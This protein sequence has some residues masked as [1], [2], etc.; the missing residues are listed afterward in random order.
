[1]RNRKAELETLRA[2]LA[3]RLESFE[4]HQQRKDGALDKDSEERA[5]QTQNDEVVD[6][7]EEETRLELAQIKV[8]LERID[9]GVGDECEVCGEAIDPRRLQVLPYTSV[10][11][12]CAEG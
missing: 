9:Q 8:A 2:D 7:L 4:A 6:S 11:V 3:S 12:D 10:C 1:M 5:Q